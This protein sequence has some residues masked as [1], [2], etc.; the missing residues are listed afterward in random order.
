MLKR[1]RSSDWVDFG[2]I[3]VLLLFLSLFFFWRLWTPEPADRVTLLAGDFTLQYYAFSDY[4]AERLA[5]GQIPLWNPYSNAGTPFIADPQAAAWYPLRWLFIAQAGPGNW[6]IAAFL[7]EIIFHYWLAGLL[8]YAFLRDLVQQRGAALFGAVLFAYSGYH[9][10]YPMLQVSI[11]ESGVWL[12]LILLALRRAVMVPAQRWQ[13]A[14]LAALAFALSILAGHPQVILYV[15]YMAGAYL[16]FLG[17]QQRMH[18]V[19]FILLGVAVFGLG[20]ALGAIQL[21]P[22]AEAFALTSRAE[23][24]SYVE[25]GVGYR[26][27]DILQ[28]LLPNM[29]SWSPLYIGMAGILLAVSAL[30]LL[31]STEVFFW[32]GTIVVTLL[33]S[34]GM[35]TALYDLIYV[36][37]PGGSLFREQE[38]VT[39][40]LLF[41]LVV[42]AVI[43]LDWILTL[44][45]DTDDSRRRRFGWL[46]GG[47]VIIWGGF[48]L[49]GSVFGAAL[50]IEDGLLGR[51]AFVF[52]MAAL[53]A[54]WFFSQKLGS[55]ASVS[56]GFVVA[57]LVIDLFSIGMRSFNF[58]P[59]TMSDQLNA[60]VML[61]TL[62]AAPADV[63]WRVDG[64]GGVQSYGTYYRIPDIYNTGP[65]ELEAVRALRQIPVDRFWEVLAVRYLTVRDAPA[66]GLDAV[67]LGEGTNLHEQD[68]RLYELTDPR[69]MAW[70]VYDYLIGHNP[71]FTREIMADSQVNLRE[72]AVTVGA[73]PF[74]LLGERPSLASVQD[75]TRLS[76]EELTMTVSTGENA[77]LTLA[78]PNYPGWQVTVDNE[79][80]A[81]VDTYAGLIGVPI[82]PGEDQQVRLVFRPITVYLGAIISGL[83]LLLVIIVG[84]FPLWRRISS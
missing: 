45:P 39:L 13:W 30:W 3:P 21:L 24:L 19:Q 49:L 65:I 77:L 58:V 42:L 60:P 74:D 67:L 18:L 12:P 29:T 38:R 84:S 40:L 25:K 11:L 70:L 32:A 6:S 78:I 41:A 26:L 56:A 71:A 62:S 79:P 31:K 16:L 81:I 59:G 9:V 7:R 5:Q 2:L 27:V 37:L 69:P 8:M 72:M 33:L 68:Y 66:D 76:P 83:A 20:G 28:F 73:L 47:V 48:L 4:Q 82:G 17:W 14:V 46:I 80:V 63:T 44:S 57:L 75:F 34:F 10:S 23:T 52:L 54:W 55:S 15:G 22:S 1:L 50:G 43:Q 36:V 53:F 61:E 64:S 51:L 35:N